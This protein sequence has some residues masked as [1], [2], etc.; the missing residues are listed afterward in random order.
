LTDYYGPH[1]VRFVK[2]VLIPMRDGVRLAMDM[3][4]PEGDGP[5]PLVFVYQPYRKDDQTPFTGPMHYFATHGIIGAFIDCRGSGA[6]EG[7]NDDEY[8]PIE[9]QDGYDAIEWIAAQPWSNGK[10]G[11]MGVSYSGFTCVQVAAL[12]PPHLAAIVPIMFTDDRYTDDCHYRGGA[13]RCYYDIGAYG[14]SMI[15]MNS[16]PPY[17]EYSGADW[18]R[19]WEQH[20]ADNAPYILTWLANQTDGPYWR[21][22]SV[23]G[24][25]GDIKA[26]ALMIGGWRDGYCNAPLR[27]SANMSAPNRVVLGPWNHSGPR[28]ETPGPAADH[29][30]EALRWFRH[31]L[32]GEANG[33]MDGPKVA[34]YVQ[35]YDEPR[36]MRT[37]TSGYWRAEP[38]F[39][40]PGARTKTLWLSPGVLSED[41]PAKAATRFE[42][43]RYRPTVGIAG[44]LWSAGVPYGL[45]TD[46]RADE[47][48]SLTYTTAP[49]SQPLEIIGMPRAVIHADSTAP[50][51]AFVAR[52]CD[53]APDGTSALVTIGV[54]NGTRRTSL[55]RPEAMTP[56]EVYELFVDLDATAWRFDKGHRLRL[57]ISSADFP[58]LWPTPY[59]GINRLYMG[60]LRPSR[61]DLPAVPLRNG[62]GDALP[63]NEFDLFVP[64][65]ANTWYQGE[66][67]NPP[68]QIVHDLLNDRTGLKLDF[69]STYRG[70]KSMVATRTSKL[71]VWASNRDPSD[72]SAVGQHL[73]TIKRLDGVMN[74]DTS[75]NLTSTVDSFHLSIQLNV[76]VNGM[77]HH[78]ARWARSYPRAL[79]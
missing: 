52:L 51:M 65:T 43:Y 14:A 23:R 38:S 6:S 56:G 18:A 76:K 5:Y 74:I 62:A 54:L 22:G 21:P 63:G 55:E 17:P 71:T 37:A 19:L 11:M 32:M 3:H 30:P 33:A 78:Q 42:E 45:P 46:Q 15:G 60:A 41:V 67:D 59:D 72:V 40:V 75:A 79:L 68:W 69:V 70:G 53:V 47:A 39:P 34:V 25:Y 4:M 26:A 10:V 7:M 24:R 58:N 50:V 66:P 36:P 8:R 64:P 9:L 2:N 35:A 44:G 20:L 61:L 13:M 57:S 12:Q 29:W 28:T 49:L 48:Y 31:W 16:M 1:K 73:R 77:L 27:F